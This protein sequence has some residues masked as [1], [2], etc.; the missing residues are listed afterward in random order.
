MDEMLSFFSVQKDKSILSFEFVFALGRRVNRFFLRPSDL[1]SGKE[2][3]CG[4][5]ESFAQ[6]QCPGGCL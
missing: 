2:D 1:R 5:S 6:K 4:S 3:G